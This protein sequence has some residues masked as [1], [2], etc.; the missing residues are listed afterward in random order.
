MRD[1][2]F[3]VYD[4]VD[5]KWL[6]DYISPYS[7]Y[8]TIHP[9]E[10]ERYW[11]QNDNNLRVLQYIGVR[12][13][14]GDLLFEGDYVSLLNNGQELIFRIQ[15]RQDGGGTPKWILFPNWQDRKHWSI[16][17]SKLKRMGNIFD[18][19]YFTKELDIPELKPRDLLFIIYDKKNRKWISDS[20]HPVDI[21]EINLMKK[22]N[23]FKDFRN[24]D[25]FQFVGV[26]DKN[27]KLLFENDTVRAW[28]EGIQGIFKVKMSSIFDDPTWYLSHL[29]EKVE[30]WFLSAT[31]E[32]DSLIYDRGL[33]KIA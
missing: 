18:T 14:N 20:L 33:E 12:D 15:M 10:A 11:M 9:I 19:P 5:R 22:C 8:S 16:V 17:H 7:V 30:P 6:F 29:D 24:F 3:T 25:F 32:K 26:R 4:T 27:S 23:F 13:I 31:M 1:L 28:S 2:L 21:F